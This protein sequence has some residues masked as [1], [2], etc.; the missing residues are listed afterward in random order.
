MTER[1]KYIRERAEESRS[2]Q[3]QLS[4]LCEE[5]HTVLNPSL[6][7]IQEA[8]GIKLE[9]GFSFIAAKSKD[10]T[11]ENAPAT[12]QGMVLHELQTYAS[13]LSGIFHRMTSAPQDASRENLLFTGDI[14]RGRIKQTAKE[15]YDAT[16]REAV[17]GACPTLQ[18]MLDDMPLIDTALDCV[19]KEG[20]D[21]ANKLDSCGL[22]TRLREEAQAQAAVK[23]GRCK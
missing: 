11:P 1:G 13:H 10:I 8:A 16:R 5:A 12:A 21:T 6:N 17:L 23:A 9:D 3:K 7:S 15:I 14:V 22:V 19:A 4:G 2:L 20:E 18:T